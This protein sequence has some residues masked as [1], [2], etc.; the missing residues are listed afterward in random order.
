MTAPDELI[1]T[2]ATKTRMDPWEWADFIACSPDQQRAIAQ[3]YRDASWVR[4]RSVF[5][6]VLGVLLTAAQ[7][8]GAAAGIAS[9][10]TALRAL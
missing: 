1:V 7:I 4:D 9:A 2:L 6:D 3:A 8:A 10:Y 5:E